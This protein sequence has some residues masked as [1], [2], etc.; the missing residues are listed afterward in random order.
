MEALT[1][2]RKRIDEIDEAILRLLNERAGVVLEVGRVKHRTNAAV[3]VP[4][5][6]AAILQRLTGANPGPFPN[7]AVRAVFKEIISYCLNMEGPIR[8]AY[9]GPE[10]TYTHL[11]ARRY[12][13]SGCQFV[14]CETIADVVQAVAKGDAIYGMVPVENST[15]GSVALTLDEM[16]VSDLTVCGEVV[17]RIHHCLMA[18]GTDMA[19]ITEVFS[20]PQSLAQCRHWLHTH[21]PGTVLTEVA[22]NA[23]AAQLA[24]RKRGTAAVAAR[25]AAEVYGLDV[26]VE[27]IEDNARNRTRFWVVSRESHKASG[28]DKTSLLISVKHE[29]GSLYTM[30]AAFERNGV[31][32]IKIESRPS[33]MEA[34]EYLF[35]IDVLGHPDQAP[36][37]AALEEVRASCLW[38]R[39]LGSYP[40]PREPL[41]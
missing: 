33:K 2:L 32:L 31:N 36:L 28:N 21:L 13:G 12:F 10:A 16:A 34:W 5:R 39:V 14:P 22:S 24:A 19:G 18:N 35:F 37:R 17:E 26:L 4:E 30:L 11:A 23:R 8:V 6:E 41:A 40:V 27:N 3:H 29:P 15:Q 20:H 1:P 7:D 25:L 9:L 38:V